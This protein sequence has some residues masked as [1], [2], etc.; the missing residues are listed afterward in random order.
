MNGDNLNSVRREASRRFVNKNRK[1]LRDK[2]NELCNEHKEQ[3][4]P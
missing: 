2:I 3:E 1:Y 4:H